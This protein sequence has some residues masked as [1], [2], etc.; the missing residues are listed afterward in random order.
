M[1]YNSGY[2]E[3]LKNVMAGINY[4]PARPEVINGDSEQAYLD[5]Y[6]DCS[7]KIGGAVTNMLDMLDEVEKDDGH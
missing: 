3:A 5:G 2:R 1:K 7:R 4:S 6:E